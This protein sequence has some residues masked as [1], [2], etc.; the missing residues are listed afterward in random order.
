MMC[1][2]RARRNLEES[3]P[4]HNMVLVLLFQLLAI[5]AY[6]I[7]TPSL[8]KFITT[9]KTRPDELNCAEELHNQAGVC[10]RGVCHHHHC[11]SGNQPLH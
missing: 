10:T 7:L 3:F 5:S 2:S 6:A 8:Y 11:C 1:W 9:P 4:H